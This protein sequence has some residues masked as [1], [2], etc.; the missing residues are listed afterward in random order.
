M[1]SKVLLKG[2]GVFELRKKDGTVVD[3]W[4]TDNT[5]SSDGKNQVAKLLNGIDTVYFNTIAVGVGTPGASALGSEN[6]RHLATLT[7]L[8]SAQAVFEYT[9]SFGSSYAITEAGVFNNSTSGGIMLDSFSFSA[10]NV[11]SSTQLYV[12]ITVTASS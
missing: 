3:R 10:K 5:V 4:E 7:Y 8:A 12:K 1:K 11:D 6:Q 2:H 9:F